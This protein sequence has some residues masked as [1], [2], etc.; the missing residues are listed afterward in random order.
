MLASLYLAGKTGLAIAKRYS[1]RRVRKHTERHK[2]AV[3]RAGEV[4]AAINSNQP[5]PVQTAPYTSS[6]ARKQARREELLRRERQRQAAT[7]VV[8]Q[9]QRQT[10]ELLAQAA[11]YSQINETGKKIA[12]ESEKVD[13][14]AYR[15]AALEG[16]DNWVANVRR[17][18]GYFAGAIDSTALA[19]FTLHYNGVDVT[20]LLKACWVSVVR[21]LAI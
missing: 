19:A 3:I 21:G 12:S 14:W 4:A 16:L 7:S 18:L 8:W 17:R 1:R 20:P 6:K 9:P 5:L 10:A 13:T 2:A 15:N 11:G